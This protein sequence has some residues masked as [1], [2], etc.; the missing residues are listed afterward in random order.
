MNAPALRGRSGLARNMQANKQANYRIHWLVEA[1]NA[2]VGH[3]NQY[4]TGY[5]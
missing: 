5:S 4:K 2:L 3:I 1:I